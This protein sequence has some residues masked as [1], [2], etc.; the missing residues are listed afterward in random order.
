M[1]PDEVKDAYPVVNEE[2]GELK[3][4]EGV[5][6]IQLPAAVIADNLDNEVYRGDGAEIADE[7]EAHSIKV[8]MYNVR[9]LRKKFVMPV[10]KQ[11]IEEHRIDIIGTAEARPRASG[12]KVES[13]Y[14]N[15]Q[16]PKLV[17]ATSKANDRGQYGCMQCCSMERPWYTV[18]GSKCF[19]KERMVAILVDESRLL[20]TRIKIRVGS[21]VHFTAHAPHKSAASQA[22]PEQYW[23]H[24]T[25]RFLMHL[26]SDDSVLLTT[27]ANARV[28]DDDDEEKQHAAHY[29][30]FLTRLGIVSITAAEEAVNGTLHTFCS[31][32]KTKMQ[33]DTSQRRTAS[34]R[35]GSRWW[36]QSSPIC[37]KA[38]TITLWTDG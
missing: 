27:D 32:A 8:V 7:V 22:T 13:T 38:K 25:E 31:K 29:K 3:P 5:K 30:M 14:A 37:A 34:V 26:K 6:M 15:G 18:G 4:R 16:G 33:L 11:Q 9:S 19:A 28:D 10:Y 35:W 36:C 23:D 1:L 21:V 20:V 12:V 17:V 24:A 2:R